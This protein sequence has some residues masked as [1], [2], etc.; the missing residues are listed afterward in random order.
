MS[1]LITDEMVETAAAAQWHYDC[2]D[3]EFRREPDDLKDFYHNSARVALEAVAPRIAAAAWD[4]G[5]DAAQIDWKH[6]YDGHPVGP[7]EM[8][9]QCGRPNPYTY[10][11]GGES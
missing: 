4:E 8:C 3:R 7:G 6:V 11:A 2:P 5:H 9:D 1:D 10:V